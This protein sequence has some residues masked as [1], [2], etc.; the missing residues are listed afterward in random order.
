MIWIC[1]YKDSI[2]VLTTISWNFSLE[3][4]NYCMIDP[5]WTKIFTY[6]YFLLE[7]DSVKSPQSLL[8]L[9][10]LSCILGQDRTWFLISRI[11]I[12]GAIDGG[13]ALFLGLGRDLFE[14]DLLFLHCCSWFVCT[15]A[16]FFEL[17]LVLS[18]FRCFPLGVQVALNGFT[19]VKPTWIWSRILML[20]SWRSLCLA[21]DLPKNWFF[22][23]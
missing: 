18:E 17:A 4:T 21:D 12:F 19:D 2:A 6:K 15:F 10:W 1:R 3:F 11:Q 9:C 22:S 13:R 20:A 8:Y 14:V 23:L 7:W 5:F 16:A